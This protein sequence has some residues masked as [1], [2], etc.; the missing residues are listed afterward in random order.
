MLRTMMTSKIHRA[1]VT[2]ADLHYVGSV[3][4][5][6][7]LLDAA[8]LLEGEQVTIVDIDNGSRL[9]TYAIAGERG[10]GVI[11]ING[12]AAHLVHPGDLV[13]IIAY[14]MLNE[15]ELKDYSPNVVFVDDHNR[16]LESGDDPAHAPEG[17]GLLDPRQL[18]GP[19][20]ADATV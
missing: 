19:V 10:S 17:S 9:V 15:A 18:D 4:I 5:D 13:I 14:G 7:D 16:I 11:G 1:T 8:G 2:Q 20:F 3:T 6:Q 12:A